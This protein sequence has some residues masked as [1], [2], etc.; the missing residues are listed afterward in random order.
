MAGPDSVYAGGG[1]PVT[2]EQA[3]PTD[4][5]PQAQP[6]ADAAPPAPPPATDR[7]VTVSTKAGESVESVRN[8]AFDKMAADAGLSPA[9]RTEF[10]QRAGKLDDGTL[11]VPAASAKDQPRALSGAQARTAIDRGEVTLAPTQAQAGLLKLMQSRDADS[12]ANVPAGA[13]AGFGLPQAKNTFNGAPGVAGVTPEVAQA[14]LGNVAEG[15]P[16][17]NPD[18]GKVGSVSWFV[19]QGNPYVGTSADKSVTLPVEIA[20]TSGKPAMEFGEKQ[21]LEIYNRKMTEATHTAEAQLRERTGK[22]NGEPLSKTNEKEI[23]RNANRVAERAMW[24]EVG[25]KVR[26]SDSGI[27][28]VKLENSIF[29]KNGNGEFTLTSMADNVRLPKGAAAQLVEAIKTNA[30]PAE[31]GVLEAAE[32]L[33]TQEKWGGRVQGAFRVGGK[34]LIVVGIAADSYRLY[35]ATDKLKTG[36]EIAGGWAGAAAASTA[37]AAWYTPADVAGPWAWLGHGV[38]TIVAGGVGYFAGSHAAKS[39]YELTVEGKPLEIGF[40]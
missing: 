30:A 34:V 14:I 15:K 17:F 40:K 27:G 35:T 11:N 24:E 21:L 16:P 37:F 39:L 10:T 36:V 20:N 25:Q 12:I 19:T 32:K 8:K 7:G 3:A 29:S 4:T 5:R 23:S 13:A 9:A 1:R 26:A 33:A 2:T 31:P 38:G 18:L 28:K 22:T 6:V